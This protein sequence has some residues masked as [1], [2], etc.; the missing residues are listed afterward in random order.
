MIE[1]SDNKLS[2]AEQEEIRRENRQASP[3][4]RHRNLDCVSARRRKMARARQPI[5]LY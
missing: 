2:P 5:M 1:L 4:E 3:T